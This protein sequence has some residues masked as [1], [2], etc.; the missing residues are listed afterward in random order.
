MLLQ[1][2]QA[3]LQTIPLL[4]HHK[5]SLI[6]VVHDQVNWHLLVQSLQRLMVDEKVADL[7]G[8]V[9]DQNIL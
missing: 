2:I 6:D 3:K 7:M 5:S 1:L 9:I 8:I 4:S